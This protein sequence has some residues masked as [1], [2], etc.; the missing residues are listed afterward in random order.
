M[1]RGAL[2]N[3]VRSEFNEMPGLQLTLSQASRLWGLETATCSDVIDA[4]VDAAF[5]RWTS[6]GT[7]VRVERAVAFPGR[8][9]PG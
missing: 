4:L 8:L 6:K 2:V 5:L 7:V 9:L 3:R 1:E